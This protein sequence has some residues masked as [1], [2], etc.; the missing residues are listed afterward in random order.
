M[1]EAPYNYGL[2]DVNVKS[3]TIRGHMGYNTV[4]WRQCIALAE[5]GIL[6]LKSIISHHLPLDQFDEGFQLS[7]R[8]EAT[9]V[10]LTPIEN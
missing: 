6:D 2:D 5:A 8:Q 7:I 4:S 3:L 9:K 1:N 10:I